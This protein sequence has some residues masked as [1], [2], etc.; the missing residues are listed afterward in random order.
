[1]QLNCQQTHTNTYHVNIVHIVEQEFQDYFK[2]L[3][4]KH[5][6]DCYSVPEWDNHFNWGNRHFT[7]RQLQVLLKGHY[8]LASI[9][10]A[11]KSFSWLESIKRDLSH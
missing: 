2:V 3:L 6:E 7:L 5:D 9:V 4:H 1:M 10:P 11:I 8:Q